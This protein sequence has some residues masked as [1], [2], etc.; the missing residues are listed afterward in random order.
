MPYWSGAILPSIQAL[1]LTAEGLAKV[2]TPVLTIHGT[3]DRSAAYGGGQDWVLSL[4]NARLVTVENAG[5]APWIE[6]PETVF[7]AIGGFLALDHVPSSG[8]A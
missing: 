8:Q 4:P 1:G 2:E 5:H 7:E 6:A 3:K